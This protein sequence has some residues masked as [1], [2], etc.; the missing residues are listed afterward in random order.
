M[1]LIWSV[2][3]VNASSEKEIMLQTEI[4]YDHYQVYLNE[5]NNLDL[6]SGMVI[7]E[8]EDVVYNL[9]QVVANDAKVLGDLVRNSN[10][11][12]VIVTGNVVKDNQEKNKVKVE[13]YKPGFIYTILS[14]LPF[15]GGPMKAQYEKDVSNRLRVLY[16]YYKIKKESGDILADEYRKTVESIIGDDIHNIATQKVSAVKVDAVYRESVSSEELGTLSEEDKAVMETAQTMTKAG[17]E[18]YKDAIEAVTSGGI[19]VQV[20]DI[21]EPIEGHEDVEIDTSTGEPVDVK[22]DVNDNAVKIELQKETIKMIKGGMQGELGLSDVVDL[23]NTLLEESSEEKVDSNNEPQRTSVISTRNSVPRIERRTRKVDLSKEDKEEVPVVEEKKTDVIVLTED[24]SVIVEDVK[25][26]DVKVDQG[27]II[28]EELVSDE[29]DCPEWV[30]EGKILDASIIDLNAKYGD[31]YQGISSKVSRS[32]V[33]KNTNEIKVEEKNCVV[34]IESEEVKLQ[35]EDNETKKENLDCVASC[36]LE[37]N[38]D[39]KCGANV[40]NSV[41]Y[42]ACIICVDFRAGIP[43]PTKDFIMDPEDCGDSGIYNAEDYPDKDK[44]DFWWGIQA[45]KRGVDDQLE[46]CLG[47]CLK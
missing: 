21:D 13:V 24:K 32:C 5:K 14:A 1:I 11:D 6:F 38:Y 33:N 47:K 10:N 9:G 25:I 42:R 45:C 15:I 36:N 8:Q 34:L 17:V 40:L 23:S 30:C 12:F 44:C 29:W 4:L 16:T 3:L 37:W 43:I 39:V 2:I 35:Y 31:K 28:V 26:D 22:I 7:K 20:D 41:F 46:M 19:D 18:F 27:E